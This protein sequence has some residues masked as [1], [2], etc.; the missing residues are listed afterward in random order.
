MTFWKSKQAN[1][2]QFQLPLKKTLPN[3][4]KESESLQRKQMLKSGANVNVLELQKFDWKY[5]L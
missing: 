2:W 3:V 4:E 5:L 1:S